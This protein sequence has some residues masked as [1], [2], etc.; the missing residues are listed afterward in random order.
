MSYDD[1]FPT[2]LFFEEG[3]DR[4]GMWKFWIG[5]EGGFSL[6]GTAW[7]WEF[8]EQ[9]ILFFS[10]LGKAEL[11]VE[12]STESKIQ[13]RFFYIRGTP[14]ENCGDTDVNMETS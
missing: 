12:F 2:D 1:C 8:L 3:V 13:S 14:L 9:E 10:G 6:L 11:F 7:S 5:G 4:S